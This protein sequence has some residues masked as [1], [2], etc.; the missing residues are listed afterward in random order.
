MTRIIFVRHG[1]TLHNVELVITSG[2]PGGPLTER[3]VEQVGLL[4]KRL[5]GL[6]PPV[7]AVYSSPLRRALQSATILADSLALVPTVREELRECSV[8]ELEGRSGPE[9][10]ERFD[11]TWDH[12]YSD[13]SPDLDYPLGPGGETGREAV[14]R[15]SGLVDEITVAHRDETV[16]VVGH[17]TVLQLALTWL[18]TN[19]TQA[20]GHRHWIANAGTVVLDRTE[21]GLVCREWSGEQVPDEAARDS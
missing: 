21:R 9:A 2:A 4:A 5:T 6:R 11:R 16:V 7:T 13:A 12:W 10:F 18:S 8:G 17:G 3:G 15:I 19:L 20:S 1:E 14:D